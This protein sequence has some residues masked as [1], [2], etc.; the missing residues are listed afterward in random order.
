MVAVTPEERGV[1]GLGSATAKVADLWI[2]MTSHGCTP[3]WW[4]AHSQQA[5]HEI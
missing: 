2:V 4:S 3:G 1:N 5:V